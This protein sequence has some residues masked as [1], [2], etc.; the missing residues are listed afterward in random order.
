MGLESIPEST[1]SMQISES[2]SVFSGG[3]TYVPRYLP[4]SSRVPTTSPVQN[5]LKRT[6]VHRGH[7]GVEG[8]GET[9]AGEALFFISTHTATDSVSPDVQVSTS[10][11]KN[12]GN[13][14]HQQAPA[15]FC[16]CSSLFM[17]VFNSW[18]QLEWRD[19][20]LH[21]LTKTNRIFKSWP[22]SL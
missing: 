15:V 18:Q 1:S 6:E 22:V 7:S 19:W 20:V 8:G 16:S 17:C 10:R 5:G 2:P 4:I 3:H 12:R 14:L 11:A 21:T 13:V 9:H